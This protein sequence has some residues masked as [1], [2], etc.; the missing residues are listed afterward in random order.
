MS[1]YFVGVTPSIQVA[2]S[3]PNFREN[4]SVFWT[5][6]RA[7][8]WTPNRANS[9]P[10]ESCWARG[11]GRG[12]VY[13]FCPVHTSPASSAAHGTPQRSPGNQAINEEARPL[14]IT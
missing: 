5:V 13:F 7:D 6:N 10:S 14:V 1:S 8:T 2:G 4:A 3:K 12:K 9:C 11:G